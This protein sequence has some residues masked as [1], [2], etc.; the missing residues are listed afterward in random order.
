MILAHYKIIFDYCIGDATAIF[1]VNRE[2]N[3]FCCY[4]ASYIRVPEKDIDY[5]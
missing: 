4:S 5:S 2:I 1:L 3:V